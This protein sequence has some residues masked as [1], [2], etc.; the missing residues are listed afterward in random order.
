MLTQ[1]ILAE[2]AS[3]CQHRDL[4]KA[5]LVLDQFGRLDGSVRRRVLFEL[6]RCPDEF[7]IPLLVY[8]S[9]RQQS[10]AEH[11]PVLTEI[12]RDKALNNPSVI[13]G[14]LRADEPDVSAYLLLIEQLQLKTAVPAL[15]RLLGQATDKTVIRQ[16]LL[17][18]GVVGDETV[19]EP[20][21]EFLYTGDPDITE[22]AFEVLGRL[23]LAKA[24]RR[25]NELLG[26][27]NAGLRNQAWRQLVRVGSPAVPLLLENLL[28]SDKDRRILSLNILQEIA[29]PAS[30]EA[31][32]RLVTSRPPDPNERFAAYEALAA[33]PL[34]K[35]DY[36]LA[37]GLTDNDAG[38]RIAAARAIDRH[39]DDSLFNGIMN[40]LKTG[41]DEAAQIAKAVIDAQT[42]TL[43]IRLLAQPFFERVFIAYIGGKVAPEVR[44]FYIGLLRETDGADMVRR[45]EALS[46]DQVS[47]TPRP[48][49]AAVD[50][51][52]LIL[53]MYQSVL[54]ELGY[55]PVLFDQPQAL[56]K[57][58][59]TNHPQTVF[60]DLNMPDMNGIDLL[61]RLRT[62]YRPESLP[63]FI[64]TTQ[65]ETRDVAEAMQLGANGFIAK[66]F[67][68][69][70]LGAALTG[71]SR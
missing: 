47:T 10:A 2:L 8:L 13:F 14:H 59:E 70:T 16:V 22:T 18:M 51:S 46:Q 6:N 62:R 43:A 58:L 66:P 56:L 54:N 4:I 5:R 49:I 40:L 71:G 50:D 9:V 42:E 33:L 36:I 27:D 37:A 29:D 30:V 64:V 35:G 24:R 53:K 65:Q 3:N 1:H 21:A 69:E 39:L 25:L 41:N 61:R 26:S 44:R 12:I 57:W 15:L 55:E 17:I 45:I 28:L 34:R 52:R 60:S 68:A 32:R 63:V 11:F 23:P 67:T 38:I 7:A 31:V 48:L 20:V 19:V